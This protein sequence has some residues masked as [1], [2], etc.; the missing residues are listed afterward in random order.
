MNGNWGQ[1]STWS[2]CSASCGPG[3]RERKRACDSPIP[4]DG[5]KPCSGSD[6]QVGDCSYRPCPG[7]EAQKSVGQRR[8]SLK[9]RQIKTTIP[10][11]VSVTVALNDSIFNSSARYCHGIAMQTSVLYSNIVS[12][13]PLSV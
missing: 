4:L 8:M 3:T 7:K 9:R 13:P 6:K 2:V 1:W 5:G 12:L 11:C 10:I